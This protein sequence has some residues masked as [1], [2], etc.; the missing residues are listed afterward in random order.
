ML[1]IVIKSRCDFFF[2]EFSKGD[3]C[4]LKDRLDE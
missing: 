1:G 4:E 2:L 3:K